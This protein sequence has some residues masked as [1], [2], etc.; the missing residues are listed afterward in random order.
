MSLLASMLLNRW[1]LGSWYIPQASVFLLYFRIFERAYPFII[2]T[3]ND[4]DISLASV[5]FISVIGQTD[6]FRI[7][8]VNSSLRLNWCLCLFLWHWSIDRWSQC[9]WLSLFLYLYANRSIF[10]SSCQLHLETWLLS[11]SALFVSLSERKLL[12]FIRSMG[13]GD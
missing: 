10:D 13:I 11:P 7:R 12:R 1:Y 9:T 2:P 5:R 3:G 8:S 6:P 4:W